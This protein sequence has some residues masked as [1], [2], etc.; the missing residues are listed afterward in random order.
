MLGILLTLL[1]LWILWKLGI[2]TI[3]ILGLLFVI[4]AVGFI[5]HFLLIPAIV[6]G[7]A[8]VIFGAIQS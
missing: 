5:F 3:K 8:I 2:F 6:I 1:F 7:L 4:F